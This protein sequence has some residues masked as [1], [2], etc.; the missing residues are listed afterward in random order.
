MAGTG[1]ATSTRLALTCYKLIRKIRAIDLSPAST[2]GM[3]APGPDLE[4]GK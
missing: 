2:P 1:L 3:P 4:I